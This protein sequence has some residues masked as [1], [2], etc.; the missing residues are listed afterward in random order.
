MNYFPKSGPLDGDTT[1]VQQDALQ[2]LLVALK[3]I[4]V[5]NQELSR[6]APGRLNCRDLAKVRV[7]DQP[8]E[9]FLESECVKRVAHFRK[10]RMV[11]RVTYLQAE[12][13]GHE[14]IAKIADYDETPRV[15]WQYDAIELIFSHE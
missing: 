7:L 12:I 15:G 11:N 4:L 2:Y 9:T 8:D 5:A 13:P 1:F 6:L 14:R 3:Q 10:S